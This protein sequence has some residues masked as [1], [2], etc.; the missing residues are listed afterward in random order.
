MHHPLANV[1]ACA[2][3][4]DLENFEFDEVDGALQPGDMFLLLCCDGV[5]KT[6]PDTTLATLLARRERTFLAETLMAA[7]LN[8]DA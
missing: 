1:I 8:K 7:A 3:G 4:A 2:V 6:L 5:F